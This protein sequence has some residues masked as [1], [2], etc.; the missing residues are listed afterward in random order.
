MALLRL[1]DQRIPLLLFVLCFSIVSQESATEVCSNTIL[2]G[3]KG[4]AQWFHF[5]LA[6]VAASYRHAV[7]TVLSD[8]SRLDISGY[9]FL[10]LSESFRKCYSKQ[11]THDVVDVEMS[12]VRVLFVEVMTLILMRAA[13]T[14]WFV[15]FDQIRVNVKASVCVGHANVVK[16][17]LKMQLLE[18]LNNQPNI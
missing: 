11:R 17:N 5:L 1:R 15:Y 14:I 16:S 2:P 6:Y 13:Q 18:K 12:V 9:F 10:S 8:T 7:V 4:I 3:L